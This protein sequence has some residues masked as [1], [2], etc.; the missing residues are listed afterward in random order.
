MVSNTSVSLVSLLSCRSPYPSSTERADQ[1]TLIAHHLSNMGVPPPGLS[2]ASLFFSL[3][4]FKSSLKVFAIRDTPSAYSPAPTAPSLSR[5]VPGPGLSFHRD[6]HC[7]Y[8]SREHP[9]GDTWVHQSSVWAAASVV[10][11]AELREAVPFCW[12][13]PVAPWSSWQKFST[14]AEHPSMERATPH[15]VCLPWPLLLSIGSIYT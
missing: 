7:R 5:G 14:L 4:H 9:A 6:S 8:P 15:P 1:R 10:A 11:A 12:V 2:L 13:D 3:S